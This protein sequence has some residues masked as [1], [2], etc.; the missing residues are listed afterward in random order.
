MCVCVHTCVRAHVCARGHV[1]VRACVCARIL[2][3]QDLGNDSLL[4]P[5]HTKHLPRAVRVLEYPTCPSGTTASAE[6]AQMHERAGGE[7]LRWLCLGSAS[8]LKNGA[9]R[10]ADSPRR[11]PAA[12]Q[13]A[14][15]T[16]SL[17]HLRQPS[18]I[19][20]RGLADRKH[21]VA[22]AG[23]VQQARRTIQHAADRMRHTARSGRHAQLAAATPTPHARP[24]TCP[25]CVVRGQ[26][27]IVR[28]RTAAGWAGAGFRADPSHDMHSGPSFSSKK[29][30]PS[31]ESR[32]RCGPS[33]GADV[34]R[35]AAQTCEARDGTCSSATAIAARAISQRGAPGMHAGRQ[36]GGPA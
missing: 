22:A 21:A 4:R 15:S 29:F 10:G 30:V 25:G 17:A 13:S 9:P 31:C 26:P 12:R 20:R 18:Q 34:G 8:G 35:V 27:L 14:Q 6:R 28:I 7:D 1:C 11:R 24:A 2:Q 5:L 36:P 33:R 19:R 32:R 16:A 23:D 3:L